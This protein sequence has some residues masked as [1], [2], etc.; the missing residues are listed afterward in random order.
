MALKDLFK[1][2]DKTKKEDTQAKEENLGVQFDID[3][4]KKK[5]IVKTIQTMRDDF[6]NSRSEFMGIREECVRQYEG[7]KKNSDIPWPD[8]S[9]ISTMVTTVA[10][11]LLHSK[12]FGMSWNAKSIY[13][14]GTEENDAAVAEMN[15]IV[16]A[17]VVSTEMK[18]QNDIDDLVHMLVIDGTVCVKKVWK[19]YYKWVKHL[20]MKQDI[21][22]NML[23]TGKP[24]YEA[25]YDYMRFEKCFIELRP[26]EHVYFAY[27][28]NS[29]LPNWEDE[30]DIIDER[31]YTLA[32]L[33]EMQKQGVIAQNIKFE[34]FK[35]QMD[36]L[37][38]FKGTSKER[39]S[40]EGS[41]ETN[42]RK[43]NY[44]LRCLEAEIMYDI[45]KDGVREKCI[46]FICDSLSLYLSGKPITAV[47][48]IG[49]SSWLIRPFLRRPGRVYGKAYPS[50]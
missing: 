17:Y 23:I 25:Q 31:W 19:P 3:D 37:P 24:E 39:M 18:M 1:K 38:E 15:K 13:W 20:K 11:D 6:E 46:F 29:Q 27:D 5:E 50:W 35:G 8:H 30:A 36:S 16:M 9:N 32:Q 49:R 14:E 4:T 42:T 33:K 12:L 34:D 22:P 28:A 45:N 47:S 2:S 10:C 44:K 48:R 21:T 40:A 43:E 41:V 26:L 7:I